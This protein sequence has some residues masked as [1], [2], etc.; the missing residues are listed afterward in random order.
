MILFLWQI[1]SFRY[2]MILVDIRR[3]VFSISPW[4]S[5][6]LH[7]LHIIL[8]ILAYCADV[9]GWVCCGSPFCVL[10]IWQDI[11]N[12]IHFPKQNSLFF[13][14]QPANPFYY[15]WF[16]NM[17][18]AWQTIFFLIVNYWISNE[19]QTNF[20]LLTAALSIGFFFTWQIFP[21]NY[22]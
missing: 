22:L 12:M 13:P 19:K 7:F 5:K 14:L 15:F 1:F 2:L 18:K 4:S 9:I 10:V 6:S 17:Q 21:C 8:R 20:A 3:N 11:V 16:Q